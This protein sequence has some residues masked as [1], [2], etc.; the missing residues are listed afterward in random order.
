MATKF[1]S[2]RVILNVGYEKTVGKVKIDQ[3]HERINT[4][5]QNLKLFQR[6]ADEFLYRFETVDET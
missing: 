2:I 1:K 5:K 6:T 3:K 4:S